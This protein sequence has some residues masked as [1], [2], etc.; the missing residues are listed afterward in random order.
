[1]TRWTIH[2]EKCLKILKERLKD[3]IK[4]SPQY[5]EIIGDRKLIR[6]LRG[7]NNDI[8]KIYIMF[9]N[10]LKWRLDNNMNEIRTNIVENGYDHPLKFPKGDIILKLIPQ[11]IVLPEAL[12]KTGSPICVEQY[13]FIPSEV[14]QYITIEDYIVFVKYSLEYRSLIV[15]QLSEHRERAY[16]AG[17]SDIEREKL[18]LSETETYGVLVNTC[19]IRDLSKYCIVY[20]SSVCIV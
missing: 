13:N 4:E 6:Y 10:F 12:D 8:E 18:E 7:H 11:L 15:E 9:K 17:L 19:V 2:E 16:L 5:P 14:F 1:M 20:G 3:D